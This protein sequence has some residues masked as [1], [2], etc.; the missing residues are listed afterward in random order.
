MKI[1]ELLLETGCFGHLTFKEPEA[2]FW[3][4]WGEA[5]RVS[6]SYKKKTTLFV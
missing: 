6:R 1:S 2:L 3:V 4:S 5:I